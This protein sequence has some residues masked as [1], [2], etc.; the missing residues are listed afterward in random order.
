LAYFQQLSAQALSKKYDDQ[1]SLELQSYARR[2]NS[3]GHRVLF[4]PQIQQLSIADA[5]TMAEF[6]THIY[7]P[8]LEMIDETDLGIFVSQPIQVLCLDGVQRLSVET[9]MQL[10]HWKPD[11]PYNRISF[12]GVQS[13]SVASLRAI[14]DIKRGHLYFNGLQSISEADQGYLSEQLSR[15][16]L[17]LDGLVSVLGPSFTINHERLY[18]ER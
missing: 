16:E 6:A 13:L 1:I 9:A 14:G 3:I 15:D 7:L 12:N 18:R 4:L 11:T 5:R 10:Q 17:G 2:E 8:N